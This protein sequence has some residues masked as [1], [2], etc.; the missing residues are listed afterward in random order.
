MSIVEERDMQDE[1][2]ASLSSEEQKIQ[3]ELMDAKRLGTFL[4]EAK[5]LDKQMI[6]TYFGEAKKFNQLVC[7]EFLF[8]FNFR[9]LPIDSCW[10]LIFIKSGLPK[11]G[12]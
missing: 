11:E 3:D 10:R 5:G 8:R 6:G 2:Q 12:Q 4:Y 7:K 9:K 1:Q